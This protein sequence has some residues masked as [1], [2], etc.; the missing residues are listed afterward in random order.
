MIQF[1]LS[2][3]YVWKFVSTL[4]LGCSYVWSIRKFILWLNET[5]VFYII[6]ML[7]FYSWWIA[8]I[9]LH[10]WTEFTTIML[11]TSV[12]K[13]TNFCICCCCWVYSWK[14]C[15]ESRF[16][17]RFKRLIWNSEACGSLSVYVRT[18]QHW[19]MNE[20]SWLW[21]FNQGLS[22]KNLV[23]GVHAAFS[24]FYHNRLLI[25]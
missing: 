10:S 23:I 8:T 3:K 4:V 6:L 13:N 21:N 7:F 22:I 19:L 15:M 9:W 17:L 11:L 5:A 14:L 12:W 20:N 1:P 16:V 18:L 2:L 24:L 25:N